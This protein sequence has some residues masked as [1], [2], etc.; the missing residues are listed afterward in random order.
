MEEKKRKN[1]QRIGRS[2][3]K[4]SGLVEEEASEEKVKRS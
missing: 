3:F 2:R 1:A 4:N